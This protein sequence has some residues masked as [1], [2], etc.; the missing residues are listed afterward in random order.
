MYTRVILYIQE[1]D[2]ATWERARQAASQH[3]KSL[4]SLVI[5][6]REKLEAVGSTNNITE[7]IALREKLAAIEAVVNA[8]TRE[9]VS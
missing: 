5:A 8:D 7:I 2:K 1:S 3:S 6:L 4:S 9:M